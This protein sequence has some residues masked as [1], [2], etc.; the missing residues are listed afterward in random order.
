MHLCTYAEDSSSH[1][2][3]GPLRVHSC[4]SVY[5]FCDFEYNCVPARLVFVNFFGRCKGRPVRNGPFQGV[6]FVVVLNFG[7]GFCEI[8]LALS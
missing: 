7:I 3:L 2:A 8:G 6:L 5:L 4:K 1:P